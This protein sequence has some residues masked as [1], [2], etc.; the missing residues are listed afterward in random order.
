MNDRPTA[1]ELLRA[2]EQFLEN[3]VVPHTD[4]V[5]RFH[6]RVAANVVAMVAREL[7]CE[8]AHGSAE[9]E[10]LATLLEDAGAFP[11]TRAE[12]RETLLARNAALVER[13]RAGDADAGP[14]REQLLA[15]LATTCAEKLEVSRPP[16]QRGGR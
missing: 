16:R 6:A 10:R 9:W 8:D 11:T 4:G 15:H 12:R 1:E 13:I 2:V 5:R 3:D 14:W 7:E